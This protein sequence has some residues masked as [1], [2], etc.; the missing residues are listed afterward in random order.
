M[1]I[2]II[3]MTSTQVILKTLDM[4]FLKLYTNFISTLVGNIHIG[5]A[6]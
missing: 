1:M 6:L 5:N 3:K 4:R 2:L